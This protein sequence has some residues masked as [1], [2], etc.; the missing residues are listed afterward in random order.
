M[1]PTL[2]SFAV[3]PVVVLPVIGGRGVLGGA[4]TA[5][6]A[7][8][9]DEPDAAVVGDPAAVVAGPAVVGAVVAFLLLL[10]AP[11]RVSPTTA[12]TKPLFVFTTCVPLRKFEI[13]VNTDP[14]TGR[15][16]GRKPG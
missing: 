16:P 4:V 13:E 3:T 5:V 8:V 11:R 9:V 6:L 2:I 7:A 15:R 12:T 10:Q 1:E 14:N